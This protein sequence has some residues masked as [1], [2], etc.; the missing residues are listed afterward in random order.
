M[1]R[2]RNIEFKLKL[3]KIMK[4]ALTIE[5]DLCKYVYDVFD[6]KI[7]AKKK[8]VFLKKKHPSGYKFWV[9]KVE[10]LKEKEEQ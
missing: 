8:K 6:N 7:D 10:E 1:K 2:Y 9:K 5:C 3:F 4:Y